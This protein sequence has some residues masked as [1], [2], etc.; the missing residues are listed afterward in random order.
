[1]S[2]TNI[3]SNNKVKTMVDEVIKNIPMYKSAD[4]TMRERLSEFSDWLITSAKENPYTYSDYPLDQFKKMM[5]T[6]VFIGGMHKSG[7]T[8]LRNVLDNHPELLVLPTDGKGFSLIHEC[9]K[10]GTEG[11]ERALRQ[12][13]VELIEPLGG[14][15]PNWILSK[16][17][18]DIQPYMDFARYFF[19]IKNPL[20]MKKGFLIL[21]S[22]LMP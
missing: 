16:C 11:I 7:T 3:Y 22:K 8:L 19:G 6:P 18:G 10:D 12:I 2:E 21:L 1:M 9:L 15:P 5:E 14:T 17:E 13:I 20:K 4:K